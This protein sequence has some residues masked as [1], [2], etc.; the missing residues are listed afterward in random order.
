MRQPPD[1]E[2]VNRTLGATVQKLMR[3]L[4]EADRRI[5]RLTEELAEANRQAALNMGRG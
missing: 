5:R 1:L 3:E 2:I 4:N